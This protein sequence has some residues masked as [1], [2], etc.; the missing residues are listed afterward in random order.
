LS[1]G[2]GVGAL[3]RGKDYH[4]IVLRNVRKKGV[5]A[6]SLACPVPKFAVPLSVYERVLE[7]EH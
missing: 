3:G 6:R 4:L 7:A 5:E 2:L 1:N